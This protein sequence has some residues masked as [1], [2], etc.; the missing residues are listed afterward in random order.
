MPNLN[1]ADELMYEIFYQKILELIKNYGGQKM[2]KVADLVNY[3]DIDWIKY[4]IYLRILILYIIFLFS[5]S[6]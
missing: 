1:D 4:N 6:I 5:E 2:S 3:R